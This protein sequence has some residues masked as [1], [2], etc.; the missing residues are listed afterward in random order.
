VYPYLR[1]RLFTPE[2]AVLTNLTSFGRAESIQLGPYMDGIVGI[3]LRAY[4]ASSDGMIVDG[5]LGYVWS[6]HDALLDFAVEALARLE[7]GSVVDQRA[8]VR[9][10]GATPSFDSLLGRVVFRAVWDGRSH[11]TQRTPVTLGGD[12]GLR[13]YEPQQFFV[14]GGSRMVGTLEYRTRPWLL[15]SVH[16]GA[17]AFY[18]VGTVYTRL[19]DAVFH[20]TVGT[21]L[22]VLFPQLNRTVFSIDVGLPLRQGGFA[23]GLSYSSEQ[24]V[25][26]TATEDLE[27]TSR[28]TTSP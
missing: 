23:V 19:S 10:R 26:L 2:Y 22:R 28:A 27:A 24:A 1:Y 21:G 4:G 14:Y 25:L 17:V 18:D 5:T 16:I 11:D 3:P 13:G 12:N 7:S 15:Q 9:V 20:H 6:E 8:I